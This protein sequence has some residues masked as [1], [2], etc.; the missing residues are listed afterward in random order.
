M[1][2]GHLSAPPTN[3]STYSNQNASTQLWLAAS[4]NESVSLA[5][6][7]GHPRSELNATK[8]RFAT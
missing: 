6:Q 7:I 4:I 3:V 2:V 8:G 5:R 1:Q